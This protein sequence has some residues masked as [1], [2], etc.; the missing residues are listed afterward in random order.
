MNRR[1]F[2]SSPLGGYKAVDARV[3]R[4]DAR[5]DLV[6]RNEDFLKALASSEVQETLAKAR[7]ILR[8]ERHSG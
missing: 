4:V 8:E 6:V 5:T 2:G 7:A 3:T 1:R